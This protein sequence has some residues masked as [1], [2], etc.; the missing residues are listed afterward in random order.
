MPLVCP[1]APDSVRQSLQADF[2][3]QRAHCGVGH[4]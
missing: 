2:T 1:A 3:D 4:G